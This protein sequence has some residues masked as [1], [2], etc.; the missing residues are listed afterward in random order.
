MQKKSCYYWQGL[1][2]CSKA[3]VIPLDSLSAKDIAPKTNAP[4]NH[5]FNQ[6]FSNHK[7]RE[8]FNQPDPVFFPIRLVVNDNEVTRIIVQPA[9]SSIPVTI[10]VASMLYMAS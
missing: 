6:V 4:K 7:N 9:P 5:K 3:T 8:H 1:N 2:C 10:A